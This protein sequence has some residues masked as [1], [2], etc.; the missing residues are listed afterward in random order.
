MTNFRFSGS[1]DCVLPDPNTQFRACVTTTNGAAGIHRPL[2]QRAM[3]RVDFVEQFL[4]DD[5]H[6]RLLQPHRPSLP[7]VALPRRR[8]AGPALNSF[9]SRWGVNMIITL[10]ALGPS[11]VL[12]TTPG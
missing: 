9:V 11:P 1:A 6:E 10:A 7:A 5:E 2:G 8:R 4:D 3:P 12:R